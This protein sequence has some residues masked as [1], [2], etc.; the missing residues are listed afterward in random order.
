MTH[1]ERQITVTIS[2]AESV[3]RIHTKDA[4]VKESILNLEFSRDLLFKMMEFASMIY[5]D[6]GFAVLFEI[7]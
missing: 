5:N 7:D 2:K 4:M 3:F 1:E 6:K